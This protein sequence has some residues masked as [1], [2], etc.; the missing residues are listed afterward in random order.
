MVNPRFSGMRCP[1]MYQTLMILTLCF[2]TFF[3]G[4]LEVLYF[5]FIIKSIGLSRNRLFY[6]S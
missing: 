3:L 2:E 6:E 1:W 5:L 4:G